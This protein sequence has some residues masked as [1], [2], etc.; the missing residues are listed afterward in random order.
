MEDR[1]RAVHLLKAVGLSEYEAKAYIALLTHGAPMNGYE[2]AKASGVPRSTI[3]EVLGKLVARGAATQ[4]LGVGRA[5]ESYVAMHI[6][7]FIDGYRTRFGETLDGLAETLPRVARKGRSQLVQSLSGRELIVGRMTD[8]M[9]KARSFLWLS[10]WP[11]IADDLRCRAAH[12]ATRHRWRR[13][14]TPSRTT[15]WP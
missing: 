4:A 2:V 10:I 11:E 12:R 6:D 13:P 14:T 7:G 9:E 5:A 3:Y 8:V 1:M 15:R